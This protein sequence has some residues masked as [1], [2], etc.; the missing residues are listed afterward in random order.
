MY[1]VKIYIKTSLAG[2]GIKTGSWS[3]IL[4]CQTKKGPATKGIR[5]KEEDTTYYRSVLLAIVESLKTLNTS[6]VITIYTDCIFVKNMIEGEKPEQWRRAE[7]KKPSGEEI[8]NKDLWQQYQEL[9]EKHKIEVRFSKHNDYKEE[10][11]KL[12]E[13]K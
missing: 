8:K 12:L 10:L 6:C 11:M 7:W 2:P 13:G 4:E 1:E 3:A 5:G 9:T